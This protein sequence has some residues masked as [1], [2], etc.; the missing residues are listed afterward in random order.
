MST[1]KGWYVESSPLPPG[2]GPGK[3]LAWFHA[4][5][6]REAREY[7]SRKNGIVRA[8]DAQIAPNPHAAATGE[9]SR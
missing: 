5:D 3:P 2:M 9:V 1:T 4:D 7:A 6:E 8:M